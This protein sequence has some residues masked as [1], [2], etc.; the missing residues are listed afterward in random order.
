MHVERCHFDCG[1]RSFVVSYAHV[2]SSYDDGV[3]VVDCEQVDH[4]VAL[5]DLH[6]LELDEPQMA[7]V[8]QI[9]MESGQLSSVSRF[10]DGLA[11]MGRPLTLKTAR[12]VTQAMVKRGMDNDAILSYIRDFLPSHGVQPDAACYT[13]LIQSKGHWFNR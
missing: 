9:Y 5:A 2:V 7:L 12:S 11:A 1:W 13:P 3:L 6:E 10:L 4:A 8:L